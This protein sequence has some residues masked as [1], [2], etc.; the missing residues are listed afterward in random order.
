MPWNVGTLRKTASAGAWSMPSLGRC[1]S[2]RGEGTG[3]TTFGKKSEEQREHVG[4][5]S[6]G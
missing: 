1:G 6:L 3:H 2:Q 4:T 5:S